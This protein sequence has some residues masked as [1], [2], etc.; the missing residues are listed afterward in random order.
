MNETN[1]PGR[2]LAVYAIP[3]SKDGEKTFWP[4]IGVAFTNR[5]GSITLLLDVL[6][7]GTN[8][9]QVREQKA[10]AAADVRAPNGGPRR[11]FE[12]VE[13]HS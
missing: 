3:E 7:L 10:P 6:P 1:G 8:R 11:A 2:R 5:D 12:T 9:L 13:V 4:K